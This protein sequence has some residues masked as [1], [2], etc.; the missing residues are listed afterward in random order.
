MQCQQCENKMRT[1]VSDETALSL[2]WKHRFL[3]PRWSKTLDKFYNKI[4]R[5]FE[6][7][8]LVFVGLGIFHGGF[9]NI[10]ILF[11][12]FFRIIR[13]LA[14]FSGH[15]MMKNCNFNIDTLLSP[16]CFHK[17]HMIEKIIQN[18]LQW[19]LSSVLMLVVWWAGLLLLWNCCWLLC[20]GTLLCVLC[21]T[22]VH[23]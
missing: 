13:D 5:Y 9:I 6:S 21:C 20:W 18:R 14:T 12:L 11:L 7:K 8:E 22:T 19:N 4:T 10:N 2:K 1:N 16:L 23:F 17:I 15:Q 3:I